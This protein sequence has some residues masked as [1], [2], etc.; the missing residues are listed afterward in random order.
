MFGFSSGS[1]SNS[2]SLCLLDSQ[3]SPFFS[4]CVCYWVMVH[5]LALKSSKNQLTSR[6]MPDTRIGLW[7]FMI[8]KKSKRVPESVI[9]GKSILG[10]RHGNADT[11]RTANVFK[12]S[13]G[14][15]VI[16]FVSTERLDVYYTNTPTI[17]RLYPIRTL[18][19]GWPNAGSL[20][21]ED[22]RV[23][24]QSCRL[25]KCAGSSTDKRSKMWE[26]RNSGDWSPEDRGPKGRHWKVEIPHSR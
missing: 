20:K 12:A 14:P 3:R 1:F 22:R 19:A 18:T 7:I 9:K 25:L 26:D 5:L 4:L 21:L 8:T 6:H 2:S 17:H 16:A 23:E 15:L 24:G 10:N 13:C 11:W